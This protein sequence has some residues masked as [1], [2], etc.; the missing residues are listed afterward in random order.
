M[1]SYRMWQ[2]GVKRDGEYGVNYQ[3]IIIK[4]VKIKRMNNKIIKRETRK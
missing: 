4:R 3:L 2:I 1:K